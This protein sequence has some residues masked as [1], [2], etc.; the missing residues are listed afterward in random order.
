VVV[1]D[2]GLTWDLVD[3]VHR[4]LEF[5][6]M[7]N[8]FRAGTIVA[9]VAAVIGWFVVL[10]RQTFVGHTLSVV[11]FPGASAAILLGISAAWGYYA[12][13]IVA[14][15]VIAAVPHRSRQGLSEES[16]VIGTVQAFALAAGFLFVTLYHGL[17][18]GTTTL[19][20]G[21]FLGI[22][23]AQVTALL[24]VSIAVLLVVAVVGR[25]LRFA[26]IDPQVAT[27]G[28]VPVR[29]LSFV[30]LVVLGVA[31]AAASQITGALLVF[32]LLVVPPATAQLLTARA[33]PGIALSIVIGLAITWCGL[34]LSYFDDQPIGFSI[35]S[36]AFGAYLLAQIG[37]SS[38]RA[39]RSR[40]ATP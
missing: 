17:L 9:I 11:A 24:A 16:A 40:R 26:S 20:F 25:P 31:V 28:G 19:L 6:F 35:T 18:Q 21:S 12:F 32:A 4:L 39:L 8:A 3:D 23:D 2:T 30:F 13:C 37:R 14:A 27:A 38:A 34:A 15:V 1:A 22:T 36:L 10:R 29:A 7:V 33:G 5:H